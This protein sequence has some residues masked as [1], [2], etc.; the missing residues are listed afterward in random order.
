MGNH[1]HGAG[2]FE[3]RVFQSAQGFHVQVVRRFIQHQNVAACDQGFGEVQTTP[4]TT[5]QHAHFL[6]LVTAVEVEATTIRAAGHLELAH[7]QDVESTGHV[8]PDGFF[9]RQ[10]IAVLVHKRHLDGGTNDDFTRIRLLATGDQLEQ[11]RFTGTVRADDADNRAGRD[12]EAQV[13]DQHAVAKGLAH[14]LELD[15]LA[16]QAVCHRDKDFVGFVALLVFEVAQFFKAGQTGLAL[17]LASLGVLAG[18]FQFLLQG[19]GTGFFALLFGFQTGALLGQPVRVV[20]LVRNTGAAVQ[21]QNPL[22]S[23]VQEVAIVGDSH[24]GAGV[25]LQELLQPVHRFSVQVVGRLIKQQHVGLGE[26]Q[27]A[28][29][30][31]ALLTAG[32]HT[33]VG[34]PWGQAQGVGGNFKLV[35]GIRAGGGDDGFQFSLLSSQCVK[36]GVFSA[37]GGVHLF[38]AGLGSEHFAHTAFHG[39]TH[40]VGRV[41]LGF[42]GQV[43][44]VQ[45]GHG[46]G[47]ALNFLVHTGHDLEQGGFAGTVGTQDTDLGTGEEGK[48]DVFKN[49]PLGGHDLAD[50]VHGE[51]VLG[52]CDS[53]YSAVKPYYRLRGNQAIKGCGLMGFQTRFLH[54]FAGPRGPRHRGRCP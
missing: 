54:R 24:H 9:I 18:P 43:T 52:H 7:V 12:V 1:Q 53:G 35:L 2:E 47:F 3:Q 17:G 41:E 50:A 14:A 29:G 45:A 34:I 13:V 15:H 27:T 31:A 48:G 28:Q 37:V 33:D 38:Q 19:L 25:A 20:A 30:H 23:V 32:Q 44:D 26:Q 46:N 6:L 51:N 22:S 10:R 49:V 36:V 40:G 5:G 8:F 4:L 21:F 39:F 42:L 16:T 11:G